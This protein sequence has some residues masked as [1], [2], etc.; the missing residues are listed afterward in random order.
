MRIRLAILCAKVVK[1]VLSILKRR[2]GSLPGKLA[3]KICAN[4]LNLLNYP[5]IVIVVTGTNGKTTTNNMLYQVLKKKYPSTIS[6]YN[7][8]N[9]IAGITTLILTNTNMNLKVNTDAIVIEVDE[10]TVPRVMANITCSHLLI[11]NLFRDQLDRAGEMEV[12]IRKLENATNDFKG[13]LIIN[14]D[15]PN[16]A[17]IGYGLDSLYFGV[18]RTIH[19]L[20]K[21][22]EASEGKYCFRC[23]SLL[24]YDYYHYSHIGQ[25][26][27]PNCDFGDYHK[28]S[29][30]VMDDKHQ[31][32]MVDNY[33][34]NSPYSTIYAIYNCMAVIT[35]AHCLS[36]NDEVI[37]SVFKGFAMNDGRMETFNIN[38]NKYLMNLIKNPTGANE[39]IKYISK[40]QSKHNIWLVLNDNGQDGRDVSWIYDVNYELMLNENVEEIVCSGTRAFD[41]ALC[42]KYHNYK[43]KIVVFEDD[44]LAANHLIN[45]N[46]K[47]YIL[48][49]YTALQK[50]R[51]ILKGH[52]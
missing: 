14:G 43:G 36:I 16:V 41:M 12:I 27:C 42:V 7:G 22:N 32:F 19:S 30:E 8:D 37:N 40:D 21:T 49:T 25:Y 52:K 10:I 51:K 50:V 28:L 3:M 15:D 31:S 44:E 33:L 39:V 6:N 29:G 45:L 17:R 9:L 11:N 48:V 5:N 46:N 35:L 24:D 47:G 1:I 13:K 34:F 23:N 2:G 38:N 4:P 26:H 20:D 18:N